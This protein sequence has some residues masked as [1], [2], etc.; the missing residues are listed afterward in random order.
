MV[1]F[2]TAKTVLISR[3]F[4]IVIT[5]FGFKMRKFA[6]IVNMKQPRERPKDV[7]PAR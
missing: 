6:N 4:D 3:Q 7:F 5:A 2:M 1:A